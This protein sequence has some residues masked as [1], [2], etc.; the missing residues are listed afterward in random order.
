MRGIDGQP[1]LIRYFNRGLQCSRGEVIVLVRPGVEVDESWEWMVEAAMENPDVASIAAPVARTS[2]LSQVVV[3]GV[4]VTRSMNRVLIGARS[5]IDAANLARV[6]ALGPSSWLAIYRRSALMMIGRIDERLDPMYMD[7]D[8]ALSL[9]RLGYDCHLIPKIVGT[10]DNTEAIVRESRQ[11]HGM[12]AQRAMCRH[13]SPSLLTTAFN[14]FSEL[15]R[16]PVEPHLFRHVYQRLG[17]WMTAAA[18]RQ[19]SE[20]IR[21]FQKSRQLH[22]AAPTGLNETVIRKSLAPTKRRAA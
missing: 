16:A 7:V 13:G 19:F 2:D 18:D 12:S 11:A 5:S 10:V 20:R 3:A 9:S 8:I 6:R 21:A 17:G 22:D 4:D 14:C 1:H 15:L